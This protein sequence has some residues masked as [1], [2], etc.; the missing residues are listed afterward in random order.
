M[1]A[2]KMNG[3]KRDETEAGNGQKGE[4]VET[5][6]ES[7]GKIDLRANRIIK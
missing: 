5:K 1:E 2:E 4:S 3:E 6:A 7:R